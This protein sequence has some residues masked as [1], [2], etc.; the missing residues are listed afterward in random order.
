MVP[1]LSA[2]HE[3]RMTDSDGGPSAGQ[4][5]DDAER[6]RALAA[7]GLLDEDPQPALDR[8]T[9][10]ASRILGAPVSLVSLVDD[11]RQLF[12]SQQGLH[13]PLATERETPLG[14]SFCQHVVT[15]GEEL[16]VTDATNDPRV[17]GNGAVES[18]RAQAYAGV[19]LRTSEGHVLGSFCVLD[20][21][22][23]EWT[24][25]ELETLTDLAAA[26]ITEIELR[27][28]VGAL[29]RAEERI[30][31]LRG[32]IPVCAWCRRIRDDAG[33]WNDL[34][35][36]VETHTGARVSHGICPACTASLTESQEA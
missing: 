19:P 8:L 25:E 11:R 27:G 10:L 32:L 7:T 22:P 5:L 20:H 24:A 6:L 30:R 33:Y 26:C 23:R 13:E 28:A 16:I 9:R 1:S 35:R 36:Y 21:E 3:A 31:T 2:S 17:R 18:L 34:E 15:S 4:A 29:E 14:H 12:A